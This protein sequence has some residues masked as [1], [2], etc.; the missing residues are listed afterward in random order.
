[1]NPL[2]TV[3]SDLIET[4]IF[5]NLSPWFTTWEPKL[6]FILQNHPTKKI[7]IYFKNRVYIQKSKNSVQ[8]FFLYSDI[9][10]NVIQ[11]IESE[12]LR[13]NV[14]EFDKDNKFI[15][16]NTTV[17]DALFMDVSKYICNLQSDITINK[18][19]G[20]LITKYTLRS[21]WVNTNNFFTKWIYLRYL[22]TKKFKEN[23]LF[24]KNKK[25]INK[26]NSCIKINKVFC[27]SLLNSIIRQNKGN[28][29]LLLIINFMIKEGTIKKL[30]CG[31]LLLNYNKIC[32]N[33]VKNNLLLKSLFIILI[34]FNDLGLLPYLQL[35]YEN[36]E[37]M[38]YDNLN[39]KNLNWSKFNKTSKFSFTLMF[40]FAKIQ[41][42]LKYKYNNTKIVNSSLTT[43]NEKLE[44]T[45]TW[46][47][48]YMYMH[49][50]DDELLRSGK[51]VY[52]NI[53]YILKS[54]QKFETFY[55]N[56]DNEKT[57]STNFTE[58][59]S[60]QQN[61]DLILKTNYIN[62]NSQKLDSLKCV[63]ILN[64]HTSINKFQYNINS[65]LLL[66]Q[67][68]LKKDGT[69]LSIY[70]NKGDNK[71]LIWYNMSGYMNNI[72]LID[73]YNIV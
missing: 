14:N 23:F 35:S 15:I 12:W 60:N 37:F 57:S 36:H 70:E 13:I 22:I 45:N 30:S 46:F 63:C 24:Q 20:E 56:K 62:N 54:L 58:F 17:H 41:T 5:Y 44:L 27:H 66:N 47:F 32:N 8:P 50:I 61:R 2:L 3:L 64:K 1:M 28:N 67:I 38:V 53:N 21:D 18:K 9:L 39:K 65:L 48:I 4:T 19:I 69:N 11:N 25:F 31:C 49:L 55:V 33:I 7:E 59:K 10:P 42:K 71:F 40:I 6:R 73:I 72:K 29:L 51:N 52:A 43:Y 26:I 68:F 16:I 34:N